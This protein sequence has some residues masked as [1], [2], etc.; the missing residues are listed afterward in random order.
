MFR[1]LVNRC[2]HRCYCTST[3]LLLSP[4]PIPLLPLHVD[5]VVYLDVFR[6]HLDDTDK[7]FFLS[8]QSG[9]SRNNFKPLYNR[10]HKLLLIADAGSGDGLDSTDL[11]EGTPVVPSQF[12]PDLLSHV[13]EEDVDS[14]GE[15]TTPEPCNVSSDGLL[16]PPPSSLAMLKPVPPQTL[17]PPSAAAGGGVK[18]HFVKDKMAAKD[19]KELMAAKDFKEPL[20]NGPARVPLSQRRNPPAKLN[21]TLDLS[22]TTTTPTARLKKVLNDPLDTTPNKLQVGVV[23]VYKDVQNFSI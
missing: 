4:A 3:E 5:T 23:S 11:L 21:L 14:E 13:T 20:A 7:A 17:L 9:D 18:E 8:N 19:M 6:R 15:V 16:K 1:C 12:E 22:V 2:C 10:N